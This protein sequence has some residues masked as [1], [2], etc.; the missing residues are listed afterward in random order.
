MIGRM[1]EIQDVEE[2]RKILGTIESSLTGLE[3]EK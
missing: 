3:A 2:I 1:K